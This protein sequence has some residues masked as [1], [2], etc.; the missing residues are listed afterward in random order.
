M[1]RLGQAWLSRTRPSTLDSLNRGRR[2]GNFANDQERNE[3]VTDPA[4]MS[5]WVDVD[6]LVPPP[7]NFD[8]DNNLS[9]ANHVGFM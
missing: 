1:T 9:L 5:G 7:I 3:V 4:L 8:A 6:N 2:D